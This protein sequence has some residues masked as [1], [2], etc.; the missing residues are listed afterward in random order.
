M[1]PETGNEDTGNPK[2]R[3]VCWGLVLSSFIVLSLIWH[4]TSLDQLI[5]TEAVITSS[6]LFHSRIWDC[7]AVIAVYTLLGLISFPIVVLIP[8]T[9]AV[10]G[11]VNGFF[12]SMLALAANAAVLYSLGFYFS[13]KTLKMINPEQTKHIHKKLSRHSFLS[14]M[15]LR[16]LPAAPYTVV[17]LLAGAFRIPFF[18]Y[19][20]GTIVGIAPSVII[21]TTVG[22]RLNEILMNTFS[23][24]TLIIAAGIGVLLIILYLLFYQ[25][26]SFRTEE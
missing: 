25:F 23:H 3:L 17:N 6:R 11:V 13:R 15:I 26:R 9:A 7:L 16:L 10:F 14:I 12:Y 5:D 18:K 21:M 24:K 20:A 1:K 4:F 2:I 8:A 22:H 19:T